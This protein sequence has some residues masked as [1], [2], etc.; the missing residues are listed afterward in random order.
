[1]AT[2]T[3][4]VVTIKARRLTRAAF[5]PFGE[6]ISTE[7]I[8]PLERTGFYGDG[9]GLFRPGVLECDHPAEFL[10]RR[11]KIRDFRV[12][13]LERHLEL[14]QTFI[15]LAGHPFMV[16]VARPDAR[17]E[18]GMPAFDEIHAF[19][20]GGDTAV[21]LYRGTWHEPPFPLVDDCLTIVMSHRALTEGQLSELNERHEIDG[22]DIDKRNVAERTGAQIRI[23]LP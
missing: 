17:E 2:E 21:N 23:E 7:G 18:H 22:F 5:A 13:Y 19:F 4:R 10:L 20:V 1:M 14:T 15:P 16:V 9:S 12:R 3:E 6:V 11:S 8:D